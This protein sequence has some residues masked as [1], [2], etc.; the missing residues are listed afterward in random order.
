MDT[1]PNG[2][3]LQ[4]VLLHVVQV[5]RDD[6]DIVIIRRQQYLILKMVHFAQAHYQAFLRVLCQYVEVL[7]FNNALYLITFVFNFIFQK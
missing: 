3:H 6:L 7:L 5:Y 2:D 4:L 1:G